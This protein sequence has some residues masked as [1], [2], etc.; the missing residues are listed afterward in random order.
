MAVRWVMLCALFRQSLEQ[1]KPK[2]SFIQSENYQGRTE[3]I[4]TVKQ[5]FVEQEHFR[6]E[7][8]KNILK[9]YQ[10]SAKVGSL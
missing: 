10:I 1:Y 9:I 4:M 8:K 6:E 3:T 5:F 7:W 2:N